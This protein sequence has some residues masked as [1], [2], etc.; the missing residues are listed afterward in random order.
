MLPPSG[1]KQDCRFLKL[2]TVSTV[3]RRPLSVT[4]ISCG[5]NTRVQRPLTASNL[6]NGS[7]T[8]FRI[9][10]NSIVSA[11]PHHNSLL[12]V[13]GVSTVCILL[14]QPVH[15]YYFYILSKYSK[16]PPP[17]ASHVIKNKVISNK[18]YLIEESRTLNKHR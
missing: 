11:S 14:S 18:L 17:H 9:M 7:L 13:S 6:Q 3:D 15:F 4:Q 10:L 5:Q 2:R 1:F 12:L 8:G 16:Q